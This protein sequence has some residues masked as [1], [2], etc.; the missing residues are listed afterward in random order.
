MLPGDTAQT[1]LIIAPL[2]PTSA[3][4]VGGTALT[5]HLQHRVSRDLDFF[6]ENSED[7][8]ALRTA[9][10]SA[11][12]VVVNERSEGTL[13]C[14]FNQTKVQVL[15]ASTQR[16]LRS[17]TRVAGIRVASVEDIMA[18]KIMVIVDRGELRDYF[19][20][21]RIEQQVGLQAETGIALAVQKYN[22]QDKEMFVFSVLKVLGGF[23]DVADD[24]S[25]PVG[26]EEIEKY[27]IK[28][29]LQVA[30]RLDSFGG[31]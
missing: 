19:D 1:W 28:R 27:W 21:M 15:D 8:D 5:V 26:R 2:M 11:G 22:P 18:T 20:L 16:L 3:Y 12:N 7:L 6:L 14:L 10:R 25:L 31:A 29:Q 30:K 23:S 17:T 13:N 9:F 24:P 4:L